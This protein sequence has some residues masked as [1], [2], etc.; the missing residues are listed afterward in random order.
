M[1]RNFLT[2]ALMAIFACCLCL[3]VTSCKDDDDDNKNNGNSGTTDTEEMNDDQSVEAINAWRWLNLLTDVETQADNWTNE[4]YTVTIGTQAS[5]P[6]ERIVYVSDLKEA[7]ANF[8]V[9]A[10]CDPTMLDRNR[11]FSA[12][13]FGSMEWNISDEGAANIA[14][15]DVSSPL[16]PNLTRL[17]YCT[18]EQGADNAT[19]L[20]GTCYYRLG[21]VIEDAEGFYWVCV[22]PSFLGKK[23]NDSYW[24]NVFNAAESGKGEKTGLNPGMPDKFIY[25]K[26]NKKYNNN[27]IKLP[28]GLKENRQQNYNFNNLIWALINPDTY[29]EMVGT[30]G[31]GLCGFDYKYHGKNYLACV[32]KYWDDA[33]IW[34][35]IFN[36]THS[37]M[38]SMKELFFLYNGYHWK[39]GSTAGVWIYTSNGYKTE[40]TGSVDNDDY[41]FEMKEPG[42]GFDVT[43]YVSDPNQDKDCCSGVGSNGN[44]MA[45]STQFPS[46]Q[47]IWVMRVATGKQLD[48]QKK[49]DPYK[50]ITGVHEIYRYNAKEQQLAD[51]DNEMKV[52][53]E[54]VVPVKEHGYFVSGDVIRD[55]DGR[56]WHCIA[57][58]LDQE[59][60][61]KSGN[62]KAHFICFQDLKTAEEEIVNT[63]GK[64]GAVIN[65]SD[66]VPE[67]MAPYVCNYLLRLCDAKQNPKQFELAYYCDS[68][69]KYYSKFDVNKHSTKRDTVGPKGAEAFIHS[70]NVAYIPK[71]GRT[72][73]TQPYMRCI[74]DGTTIAGDRGAVGVN[75][76]GAYWFQYFYKKYNQTNTMTM[77]LTHLWRE[78]KTSSVYP[79][80]ADKWSS[81]KRSDTKNRDGDF[82]ETDRYTVFNAYLW[83]GQPGYFRSAYRE[84]VVFVRYMA[85]DDISENML[86][87][88]NGKEFT[89]ISSVPE[90][91]EIRHLARYSLISWANT[92]HNE[93]N[94][95]YAF[96]DNEPFNENPLLVSSSAWK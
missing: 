74:W 95:K 59:G 48:T 43:R 61:V 87:K 55:E 89:I 84:P 42:Y 73:G 77:D 94:C 7:K 40:Y 53:G 56:Y 54:I 86:D 21:D 57:G 70:I 1:K 78:S 79:I 44:R 11:T 6:T 66:L 22:R 69:F 83:Q 3:S 49:Y 51:K 39:V 68:L 75:I 52:D 76:D 90:A 25:S 46:G 30:E 15:V 13:D 8:S 80:K 71:D 16:M 82:T 9:I 63:D 45:P 88:Y 47:G 34:Q 2:N 33:N 10:G 72:T 35:K 20:T 65:N 38:N 5:N 91:G 37:Q 12:G 85:L 62:K 29:K 41:L 28:T 17:I 19:N 92:I 60:V 14:T 67:E 81:C 64:K 32:A 23:A 4:K 96:M 93:G 50:S 24:V 27:T 58:W 26:Y 31:E 36:R 18:E